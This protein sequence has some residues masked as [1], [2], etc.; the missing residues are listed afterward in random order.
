MSCFMVADD[1]INGIVAGVRKRLDS[2]NFS[3]TA[4]PTIFSLAKGLPE[5]FGR[6]LLDL[7]ASAFGE[8]YGDR[9]SD[10]KECKD[11]YA[12]QPTV[13][14]SKIELY[15]AVKCWLYQCTEGEVDKTALYL[16][17]KWFAAW[18]AEGI[19]AELPEYESAPWG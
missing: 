7:N 4:F 14:P 17:M 6:A 16:E 3:P 5:E 11:K 13:P 2:F 15:K 8:R 10:A 9:H 18:I 1:T 19:V 12:F